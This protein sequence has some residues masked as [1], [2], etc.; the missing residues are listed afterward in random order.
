VLVWFSGAGAHA[1]KRETVHILLKRSV[2][3]EMLDSYEIQQSGEDAN[4]N[5]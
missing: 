1:E 4:P 3:A 2:E 5:R